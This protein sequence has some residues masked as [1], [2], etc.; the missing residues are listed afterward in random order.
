MSLEW[1]SL[2]CV[3]TNP[4]DSTFSSHFAHLSA[5]SPHARC[6]SNIPQ[7][8]SKVFSSLPLVT[9]VSLM[10]QTTDVPMKTRGHISTRQ[11]MVR[12]MASS[13]IGVLQPLPLCCCLWAF[14][15]QLYEELSLHITMSRQRLLKKCFHI[16]EDWSVRRKWAFFLISQ[17]CDSLSPLSSSLWPRNWLQQSW[18]MFRFLKS[19]SWDR[20]GLSTEQVYIPIFGTCDRK[21]CGTQL[22]HTNHRETLLTIPFFRI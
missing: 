16:L 22:E 19:I 12:R 4:T 15:P 21:R 8:E 7:P 10:R 5:T 17:F 20:G 9:P 13:E 18:R 11:M 6:S 1:D 14:L 2:W 3:R